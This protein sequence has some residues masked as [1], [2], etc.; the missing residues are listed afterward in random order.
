MKEISHSLAQRSPKF[1]ATHWATSL[2]S[3]ANARLTSLRT[4]EERQR[5]NITELAN[6]DKTSRDR[7]VRDLNSTED[8]IA[9]AQKDLTTAEANLQ[10]AKDELANKIESLDVDQ[11]L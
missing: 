2:F 4:D 6:A 10:S 7:F 9:L 11:T 3:A 5:S 1:P 8:Q